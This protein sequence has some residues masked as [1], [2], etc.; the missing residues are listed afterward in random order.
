[1]NPVMTLFTHSTVIRI[2]TA[3]SSAIGTP[4]VVKLNNPFLS[5]NLKPTISKPL[6]HSATLGNFNSSFSWM[7]DSG[8][9]HHVTNNLYNLSLHAPYEGTDE[10]LISDGMGLKISHIGSMSLLNLTLNNIL[11]VPSITKNIISISQLCKDN[12]VNVTFSSNS[13]FIKTH[14]SE[15]IL[16][17]GPSKDG[18]YKLIYP[19]P[20]VCD[21]TTTTSLH[22]H[23]RLG[24][25]SFN[26]FRQI[27]S[28]NNLNVFIIF[29]LEYTS[30]CISKSHKLSFYTTSIV[31]TAPLQYI[32]TD[33]WTS[34]VTSYDRYKYILFLSIIFQNTYDYI[35]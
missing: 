17:Q 13:F 19:S 6:A 35:L 15:S 4:N 31:S 11:I 10:L 29:T 8:A 28:K 23:H 9:S 20:K 1:M 16:L 18:I 3:A 24:D 26:M 21:I 14:K 27:V 34:P 7:L 32:Y 2:V 30:C 33:V 12:P 25:P 22:W 5:I